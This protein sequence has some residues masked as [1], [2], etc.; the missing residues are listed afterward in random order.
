VA[1]GKF[2]SASQVEAALK[3]PA[4]VAPA[5]DHKPDKGHNADD[6]ADAPGDRG[7]AAQQA[8]SQVRRNADRHVQQQ[9]DQPVFGKAAVDEAEQEVQQQR[10]A[11]QH[12]DDPFHADIPQA[13]KLIAEKHQR[14]SPD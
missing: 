13:E 7:A 10:Y 2:A 9:V 3:L 1:G 4:Q 8:E 6:K 12:R 5:E 14:R 11:A